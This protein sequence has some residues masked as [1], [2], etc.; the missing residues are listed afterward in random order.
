MSLISV[1]VPVLSV[2]MSAVALGLSIRSDRR[3]DRALAIAE[4]DHTERK[5]E[6]EARPVLRLEI[7]PSNFKVDD[8][9]V[10]RL[11]ASN[12]YVNVAIVIQN[13]GDKP[14]G[15]TQVDAWVPAMIPSDTLKWTDPAGADHN[16]F[17]VSSPDPSIKLGTGDGR[18]FDSQRITQ[19]LESIPLMGETVYLRMNCPLDQRPGMVPVRVVA[20][21]DGSEVESTYPL[22]LV[23]K[24]N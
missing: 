3:S 20:K 12:A 23:R 6:R 11:E 18:N 14:A 16:R 5:R 10:L 19:R 13:D 7:S 1:A 17:G 9:G 22:R 15:A 8:D 2:A 4:D 24:T 21:T